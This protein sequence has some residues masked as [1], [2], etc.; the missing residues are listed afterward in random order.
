SRTDRIRL[1]ELLDLYGLERALEL[2]DGGATGAAALGR[3]L[4]EQSG[5]EP[6]AGEV[7]DRFGRRADAFK[8]GWALASVSHLRAATTHEQQRIASTIERLTLDPDLHEVHL[9]RVLQQLAVGE[10]QLPAELAEDLLALAESTGSGPG[11]TP[12]S[13]P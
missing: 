6:L 1:L 2:V 10:I 3:S 11:S 8:A 7:F 13:E 12:A 4:H 9:L 5:I